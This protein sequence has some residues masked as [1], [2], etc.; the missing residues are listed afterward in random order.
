MRTFDASS[1]IH[2][3]DN[4][5]LEQFP[6]LWRWFC[7]Q[8]AAGEFTVPAVA[9]EEV[10]RKA[11]EY[12]VWLKD[13]GIHKLPVTDEIVHEATRIKNLLGIPDDKYRSGVGENDLLIIATASVHGVDLVS[14]EGRQLPPPQIGAK[15]KIPSV[16]E[17]PEVQV[18]CLN[19]IELIRESNAI[20]GG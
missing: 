10:E 20:F 13:A 4:Y 5:P 15:R 7:E 18:R 14:N 2:A 12:G 17:L 6:P 19:L 1:L 8:I 9:L 11:P 16:C 3:W